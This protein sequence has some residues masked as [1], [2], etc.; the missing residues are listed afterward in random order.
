MDDDF[1]ELS[2]DDLMRTDLSIIAE[3]GVFSVLDS[4]FPETSFRRLGDL[5]LIEVSEHIYTK[6]WN[7]KYHAMVFAEAVVRAVT[8]LEV[9]GHP[10]SSASI[11]NDD[12]PHIFI[13]WCL[14]LPVSTAADELIASVRAADEL[15][16]KRANFILDNSD[17]VLVLGKDTDDSLLLLKDIQAE[18]ET[19]GYFVYIIK[20]QPDK[21]G[22]SVIQKV[23][24]YALSSKFV[25]VENSEPSG[26]LYEMPHV[27]KMAECIV[28]V[29]QQ[30]GRGAT[31]MFEDVYAKVANCKKF[32]YDRNELAVVVRQSVDWAEDFYKAFSTY[33]QTVL[34]WMTP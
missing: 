22:E 31:W 2:L 13:R 32:T 34:P 19:L 17:S 27:A 6:Y 8:R 20:E 3:E 30:T 26:H 5:L 11:E 1:S 16:W 14:T 12:E 7:H 23:L 29:L 15:V 9:E 18:L 10:I 21:L 28:V 33:Q 24:R 25:V 4:D